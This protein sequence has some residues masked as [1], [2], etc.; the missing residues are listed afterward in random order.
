MVFGSFPPRPLLEAKKI[1]RHERK[2]KM[3]HLELNVS[4]IFIFFQSF[5]LCRQVKCNICGLN[6]TMSNLKSIL[7]HQMYRIQ[8]FIAYMLFNLSNFFQYKI[9]YSKLTFSISFD[10]FL[11]CAS[12]NNQP[13]IKTTKETHNSIKSNRDSL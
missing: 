12:K 2:K 5:S 6:T 1:H 4:F 11:L 9:I 10:T 3:T 7:M 13:K 8:I